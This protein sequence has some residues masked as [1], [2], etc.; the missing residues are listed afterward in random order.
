MLVGYLKH[1]VAVCCFGLKAGFTFTSQEY[2][3]GIVLRAGAYKME[4]VPHNVAHSTL[5]K[6]I[7]LLSTADG[8]RM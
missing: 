8:G 2:Q 7:L 3:S 1:I 5:R 4:E 6:R